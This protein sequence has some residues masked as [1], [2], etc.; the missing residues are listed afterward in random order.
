MNQVKTQE[1]ENTTLKRDSVT[2]SYLDAG[3]NS[4][5]ACFEVV[6]NFAVR[7]EKVMQEVLGTPSE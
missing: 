7:P 3:F 1:A 2:L 6:T 4:R 5:H